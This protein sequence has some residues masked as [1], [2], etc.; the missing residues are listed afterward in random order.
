MPIEFKRNRVILRELVRVEVAEPLLEALQNK[1]ATKVDLAACTH[2]HAAV[3]QVLMAARP[4][5]DKWPQDPELRTWLETVL[6]PAS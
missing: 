2:L 3:L 1:P 6:I 5:I 4:F